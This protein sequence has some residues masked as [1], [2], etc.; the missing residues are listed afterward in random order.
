MLN[1]HDSA[2]SVLNSAKPKARSCD[3]AV[4]FHSHPSRTPP[5]GTAGRGSRVK[6]HQFP[7]YCE[8]HGMMGTV[9]IAFA[10]E[11]L[12]SFELIAR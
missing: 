9:L 12:I 7:G 11:P 1:K 10:G 2:G 8:A 4:G 3:R 6:A 5:S